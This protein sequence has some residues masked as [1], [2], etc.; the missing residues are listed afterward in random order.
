MVFQLQSGREK[1]EL[2]VMPLVK[3][4]TETFKVI[5]VSNNKKNPKNIFNTFQMQE[6]GRRKNIKCYTLGSH[7]SHWKVNGSF[8]IEQKEVKTNV[9][10]GPTGRALPS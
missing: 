2:K 4:I 3:S 6:E 5:N 1:N 10:S 9:E 8:I 7:I